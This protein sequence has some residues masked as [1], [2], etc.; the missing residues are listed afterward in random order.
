MNHYR[1]I[2]YSRKTVSMV[3]LLLTAQKVTIV[4]EILEYSE[5]RIKILELG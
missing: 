5:F 2:K 4:T 1:W 3:L